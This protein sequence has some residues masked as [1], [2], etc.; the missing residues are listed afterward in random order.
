MFPDKSRAKAGPD[1]NVSMQPSRARNNTS[2]PDVRPPV[3]P[4]AAYAPTPGNRIAANQGVA[5]NDHT[6]AD[7]GAEDGAE[8]DRFS[9]RRAVCRFR[10]G[11]TVGI[12]CQANRTSESGAEMY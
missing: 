10:G 1:K 3:V 4:A 7:T 9:G 11:E 12:V 6:A 8:D 5:I 2:G